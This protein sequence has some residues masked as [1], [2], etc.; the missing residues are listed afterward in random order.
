MKWY[1]VSL[2]ATPIIPARDDLFRDEKT[3]S[4]GLK[5]VIG[6]VMVVAEYETH[7]V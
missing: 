2:E 1:G 4:A 6:K 3:F 5:D 7:R